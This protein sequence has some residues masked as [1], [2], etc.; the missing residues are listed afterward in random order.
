MHKIVAHSTSAPIFHFA[1]SHSSLSFLFFLI[2]FR[3]HSVCHTE[4]MQL[5]PCFVCNSMGMGMCLLRYCKLRNKFLRKI[6]T[7]DITVAF[8]IVLHVHCND[9]S[10]AMCVSKVI[11][12]FERSSSTSLPDSPINRFLSS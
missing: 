11:L 1:L 5:R 7:S 10:L 2:S 12:S 6:G 8:N 3:A 4:Q 9:F